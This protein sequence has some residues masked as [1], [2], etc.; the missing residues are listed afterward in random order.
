MARFVAATES[1]VHRLCSYL[2][3]PADPDDLTQETYE[4][5]LRSLHRFRGDGTARAWLM[6]IAR[7]VCADSIRYTV[8]DLR[9]VD[10]TVA[11]VEAPH[12]DELWH[13]VVDALG[14]LDRDRYEA[15]V[16]TQFL[17]L[18]YAETAQALDC[19]IGTVRSRVA[20]ARMQLLEAESSEDVSKTA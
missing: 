9:I 12:R 13:D 16:M 4:R 19:A 20:R 11:G 8:R 5:A 1:D 15:F 3:A 6:T 14:V 7:R 17:G 18:S 10:R 2:G